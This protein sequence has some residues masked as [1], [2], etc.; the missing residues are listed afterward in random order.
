[1]RVLSLHHV[2]RIRGRIERLYGEARAPRLMERLALLAARYNLGEKRADAAWDERDTVLITYGDMIRGEDDP[3]LT[4]LRRFLETNLQGAIRNVH[5]LSFYPCSSGDGDAVIDH[6]DVSKALGSWDNVRAIGDDFRLMFD[7]MLNHGSSS[8]PW[9]RYFQSGVAPARDYFIETD[10][11]TDLT[12]VERPNPRP[13]LTP[14]QTPQGEKWVWTTFSAD[15]VDLN[16]ANQDV[17]FEFLDILLFYV[18][19]GA[20]LIRLDSVEYLWKQPGTS[21]I[22]LPETH[23]IVKLLRDVLEMLAPGTLL[24]TG[25]NLPGGQNLSYFGEGDEANLICQ[26]ALAPLL[27]H[28]MYTGTSRYLSQWAAGLPSPPTGCN[29]VNFTAS[30]HG[31]SIRHL[32]GLVPESAVR[33]LVEAVRRRGGYVTTSPGEGPEEIPDELN[34]TY[35]DALSDP[36]RP[37]RDEHIARFL[38]SQTLL[39]ALRGI[40]A[41]YFHSLTATGNDYQGVKQTGRSRSINTSRWDEKELQALLDNPDSVNGQVFHELVRLLRIR[42]EH[43]AFHP[44]GTQRVLGLEDGLFGVERRSPDGS[45]TVVALNNLSLKS[46]R[47]SFKTL[48]PALSGA[49][50]KGPWRELIAGQPVHVKTG[51]YLT[52]PP[53]QSRWLLI[54]SAESP[55]RGQEDE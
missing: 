8:G 38:C 11:E 27:L 3:P 22:G 13:L 39:F 24:V 52:M 36:D 10:P 35:F 44:D 48:L 4:T 50:S 17:L 6:R 20:R 49:E 1:M 51:G 31:V 16:F 43:P 5:L 42:A 37:D 29:F 32:D 34:I 12:A 15:Q 19:N 23:E 14:V 2:E 28:A 33:E 9:F 55:E 18:E 7:L 30:Q 53:Y 40:P 54:H 21:C 46:R 41:V 25:T 45:E 47:L 26:F